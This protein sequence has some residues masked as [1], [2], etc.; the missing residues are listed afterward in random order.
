MIIKFLQSFNLKLY[1]KDLFMGKY[2]QEKMEQDR[3]NVPQHEAS[4]PCKCDLTHVCKRDM[5]LS[6]FK[7]G[8]NL[9]NKEK[10]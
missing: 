1:L 5:I 9:R 3:K 8:Q 10:K 2:L 7:N 4:T 6:C